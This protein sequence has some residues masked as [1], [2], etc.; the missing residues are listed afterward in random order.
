MVAAGHCPFARAQWEPTMDLVACR[1]SVFVRGI[2]GDER[3]VRGQAAKSAFRKKTRMVSTRP[4]DHP[5][6]TTYWKFFR[7]MFPP[8]RVLCVDRK[9]VNRTEFSY[10]KQSKR[11]TTFYMLFDCSGRSSH[12]WYH[13]VALTSPVL[14]PVMKSDS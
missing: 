3:T 1:T 10:L 8:S 14:Q 6:S 2:R 9:T 11:F 4:E 5:A 7:L 13:Y 12:P